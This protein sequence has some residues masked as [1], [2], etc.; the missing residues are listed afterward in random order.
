M[1]TMA[2]RHDLLWRVDMIL[3][4]VEPNHVYYPLRLFLASNPSMQ[5]EQCE[6]KHVYYGEML[7]ATDPKALILNPRHTP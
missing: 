5:G 6:A 7:L 3:W 2:S 4:R 1:S